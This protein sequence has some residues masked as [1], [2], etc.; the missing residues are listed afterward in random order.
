VGERQVVD[1]G[2]QPV[3]EPAQGRSSLSAA[4]R[5]LGGVGAATL[6]ASALGYVLLVASGRLLAGSGADLENFLVFWGLLFGIGAAL[7]PL[8]QEVARQSTEAAVDGRR[9]GPAVRQVTIV[10]AAV[11]VLIGVVL[12]VPPL[13]TRLFGQHHE[14]LWVA[15][16]GGFACSANLM[17]RGLLL[18]RGRI[19]AYGGLYIGESAIRLAALGTLAAAGLA[20][21]LPMTAAVAAGFLAWVG[22]APTALRMV[23]GDLPGEPWT[24]VIRRTLTLIAAAALMAT[25]L[26]GFPAMVGAFAPPDTDGQLSGLFLALV[27]ARTPLLFLSP[28]L[29]VT[30]P[31]VVRLSRDQHGRRQLRRLLVGLVTGAALVG[32]VG[33]AVGWA[34]GPFV[35]ELL[36]GSEHPVGRLVMAALVWSSVMLGAVIVL[37]AVLVARSMATMMMVTWVVVAGL[38]V[39]TLVAGPGDTAQRAVTGIAVAP[40]VGL[41]VVAV[42]VLRG[43]RS[44][45]SASSVTQ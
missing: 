39:L 6:V 31:T 16:A 15:V 36:F 2:G 30:V 43:R 5:A 7:G 27:V 38:S 34:A 12:A 10:G 28:V 23:D 42:A 33:A 20:H 26:T 11:V 22:L 24:V 17:V 1:H 41:I 44:A 13:P 4:G 25:V 18:G 19:A 9:A 35:L 32:A 29:V 14:L 8:E 37:C 21:L 40:T 45:S 3:P